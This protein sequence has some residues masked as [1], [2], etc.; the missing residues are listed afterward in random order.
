MTGKHSGM[1]LAE[2]DRV[3]FPAIAWAVVAMLAE[4]LALLIG[5][6]KGGKSWMVLQLA[7]AIATGAEFLGHA[8]VTRDVLV[9]G[10]EDNRRRIQSRARQILMGKP[11]P[12]NVEIIGVEDK[13]ERSDKGGLERIAAWV[14]EH[15][16][17]VVIIDTLGRFRPLGGNGNAYLVDLAALEPLQQLAL[18][19]HSL[20]LC[21]H[22]DNK[23]LGVKDWVYS[24]SGTQAIAG[25]A[26]TLLGLAVNPGS[27]IALL[28]LHGRDVEPQTLIVRL[29]REP[30]GW[31]FVGRVLGDATL[32]PDREEVIRKLHNARSPLQIEDLKER[33]EE[34]DACRMRLS[35][36]V[37]SGILSR[38][39]SGRT[40][41][42]SLIP[43]RVRS[44]R[45][46]RPTPKTPNVPNTSDIPDESDTSDTPNTYIHIER[47]GGEGDL[48]AAQ[49]AA[50]YPDAE[51]AS[52]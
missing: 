16:G 51:V 4:G 9:V 10:L 32:T 5:K 15:P 29:H 7:I 3:E 30:S 22:H 8:T 31:M 42:F 33:D 12:A 28:K 24:V 27:D 49:L 26:D 48:D 20:V 47:E 40:V 11:M 36:M 6:P 17:G 13:W 44:V 1:T 38:L 46:D 37:D 18:A 2:L 50:I 23:T 52:T 43:F 34:Y 45:N 14:R 41:R 21:T 39:Y 19:Q 25:T 35:R